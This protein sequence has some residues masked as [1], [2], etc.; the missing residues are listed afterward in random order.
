MF[1]RAVF[2][3]TAQTRTVSRSP[4]E[5]PVVDT[6]ILEQLLER[7]REDPT[8]LRD[9]GLRWLAL[10]FDVMRMIQSGLRGAER[11]SQLVQ[12]MRSYSRLDRGA[13]QLV[14]LHQGLEDTLQ[15]LSHRLKPGVKVKRT[16]VSLRFRLTA[17]N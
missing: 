17:A 11:V 2:G 15:L 3:R 7:W 1:C 10:S 13:K 14:D 6:K 9:M 16:L 12:S 8:E 4:T 5:A